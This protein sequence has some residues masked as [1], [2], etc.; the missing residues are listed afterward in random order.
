MGMNSATAGES[1]YTARDRRSFCPKEKKSICA[2][3]ISSCK[4]CDR[5][6]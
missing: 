6:L 3:A 4:E 2:F 5:W 1:V